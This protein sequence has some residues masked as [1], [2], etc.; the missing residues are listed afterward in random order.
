M[1]RVLIAEDMAMI[2]GALV[3]LLACEGDIEVVAQLATDADV[4]GSAYQTK[5][6]VAVIDLGTRLNDR[7]RLTRELRRAVPEC[8]PMVLTSMATP[9]ALQRALNAQV[10][11]YIVKD[12]PPGFLAD[13]IRRVAKGECVIDSRLAT[14]TLV[15]NNDPLTDREHEILEAASEG[16]SVREV[17]TRLS[18]APG[19]VRNYLSS[20]I[21]KLGARNR[22]DAVRIARE[23]GWI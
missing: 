10:S 4:V 19:T 6:D 12:A 14:F 21:G 13:S 22:V 1:I 8:H 18:L 17:A 11:G 5:P 2:R 7:L 3:A 9:R 16:A 15:G 20:I 23:S